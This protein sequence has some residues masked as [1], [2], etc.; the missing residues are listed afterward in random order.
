M[1]IQII[2]SGICDTV[3][4]QGRFGY[5][6]AGVNPGGVADIIACNLANALCGND[7]NAAILELH[8]PASEIIFQRTTL[9]SITGADF[10]PHVD[11][12]PIGMYR[13]VVVPAG[14]QLVFRR[15]LAGMRTYLAVD[16]GID[17]PLWLG[18]ASTSV[19]AHVGGFRGR[20][21]Q[22]ADMIS[23]GI[24]KLRM[25]TPVVMQARWSTQFNGV[26]E[27]RVLSYIQGPESDRIDCNLEDIS[28][29]LKPESDRM[30]LHLD[31]L[32]IPCTKHQMFSSAVTSGT[33]QLLPSG[34]AIIL[35]ADHQTTGGYPRIA[36]I[37]SSD[38]PSLAQMSPGDTFRLKCVTVEEAEKSLISIQRKLA[39]TCAA[40]RLRVQKDY[41][42]H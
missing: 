8:F 28:F 15:R 33:M 25:A 39:K 22:Q 30:A 27:K 20:K 36:N 1:S 13:P 41:E 31:H 24:S 40:V 29:R 35:M 38:L 5:A 26:Y 16:G 12:F 11:G 10:S 32:K 21:L 34:E 2:K 18:S 37:I 3:Q 19:K 7:K 9:I 17:V 42:V 6:L 14:S 4:D 23:L